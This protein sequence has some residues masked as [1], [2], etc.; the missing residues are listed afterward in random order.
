M[1]KPRDKSSLDLNSIEKW[2]QFFDKI[3]SIVE[4]VV[5]HRMDQIEKV[6]LE[7]DKTLYELWSEAEESVKKL[8]ERGRNE[9]ES[10]WEYALVHESV[11]ISYP[12]DPSE[13]EK[14]I[15]KLQDKGQFHPR[16]GRRREPKGILQKDVEAICKQIQHEYIELRMLK[17]R[18]GLSDK[19]TQK[20]NEISLPSL[21]SK[22]VTKWK[23]LIMAR[24]MTNYDNNPGLNPALQDLVKEEAK[25]DS[26]LS[27]GGYPMF[28]VG[29]IKNL[30]DFVLKINQPTDAFSAYLKDK[31]PKTVRK[32]LSNLSASR[33]GSKDAIAP[34]IEFLNSVIKGSSIYETRRFKGVV[35]RE[36]NKRMLQKKAEGKTLALL[37]RQLLEDVYPFELLRD[38]TITQLNKKIRER[39][40]KAVQSYA[41]S[42]TMPPHAKP[43]T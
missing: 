9:G 23:P 8:W 21:N 28:S 34:L 22:T 39:F 11:P 38:P 24:F 16:R 18:G 13:R 10:F 25:R 17:K 6:E 2:E 26:A 36:D 7:R 32:Q 3:D 37:N 15:K 30:K 29:D 43:K 4:C 41:N 35:L 31:L 33:K 20:L 19:E 27:K 1:S 12:R 14:L 42:Q 5:K 40:A